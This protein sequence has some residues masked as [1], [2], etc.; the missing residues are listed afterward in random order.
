MVREAVLIKEEIFNSEK[1]VKN[2]LIRCI[3]ELLHSKEKEKTI[4]PLILTYK[5]FIDKHLK[6]IM[7]IVTFELSKKTNCEPK[8]L[9]NLAAYIIQEDIKGENVIYKTIA[10]YIIHLI[11]VNHISLHNFISEMREVYSTPQGKFAYP[12]LYPYDKHQYTSPIPLLKQI[13]TRTQ[14][15]K[16]QLELLEKEYSSLK[17]LLQEKALLL[18]E[19]KN[20][21]NN[22]NNSILPTLKQIHNNENYKKRKF[23]FF[24]Q[25]K[26]F[27][28]LRYEAENTIEYCRKKLQI[29]EKDINGFKTKYKEE[30]HKED[31]LIQTIARNLSTPK[32]KIG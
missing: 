21:L 16:K 1:E 17:N 11:K 32:R 6:R 7:D 24:L 20:A 15:I 19:L 27:E 28:V 10:E 2:F 18:T 12:V 4:S 3:K 9:K 22:I 14:T 29:L 31:E 5:E 23:I 8:L 30:L 26:R 25:K 13:L